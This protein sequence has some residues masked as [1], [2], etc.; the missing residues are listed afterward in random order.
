[1]ATVVARQPTEIKVHDRTGLRASL[2]A[3][4]IVLAVTSTV[5]LV[6]EP[7]EPFY[8]DSGGYWALGSFFT[9]HGHFCYSNSTAPYV[10]ISYRSFTTVWT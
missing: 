2:I 4:A 10:D 8:Y 9:V 1:M 3:L 6:L 5:A 7:P